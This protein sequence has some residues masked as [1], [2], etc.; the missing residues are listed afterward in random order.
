MTHSEFLSLKPGTIIRN[1]SNSRFSTK[2][3]Y[4]ILDATTHKDKY[5][6]MLIASST[7]RIGIAIDWNV[8]YAV[9]YEII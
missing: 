4:M 2:E 5:K 9:Y 3:C 1:N 6:I 8:N 7:E